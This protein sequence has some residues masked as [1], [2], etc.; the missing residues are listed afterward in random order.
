LAD[1]NS[2]RFNDNPIVRHRTDVSDCSGMSGD[3]IVVIPG[4]GVEMH[5][6]LLRA[7]AVVVV[8]TGV[9]LGASTVAASAAPAP[10]ST[11]TATVAAPVKT[12]P[13]KT[14]GVTYS[15]QDWWW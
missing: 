12:A 10:H 1:L 9:T 7:A 4:K 3:K 5:R 6:V 14:T 15:Q 8:T 13:T 2:W 11:S